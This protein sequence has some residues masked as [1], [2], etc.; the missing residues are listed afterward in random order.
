MPQLGFQTVVRSCTS[1]RFRLP[2]RYQP[3]TYDHQTVPEKQPGTRDPSRRFVIRAFPVAVTLAPTRGAVVTPPPHTEV[4]SHLC[5]MRNDRTGVKPARPATP[6][7]CAALCP[8]SSDRLP[9]PH[10]HAQL[11]LRHPS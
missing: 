9:T 8:A 11:P 10:C 6:N 1:S 3:A 4:I 5:D 7:H 2:T